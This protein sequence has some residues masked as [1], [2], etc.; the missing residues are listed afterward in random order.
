MASFRSGP[1][2]PR[3]HSDAIPAAI[4]NLL[5]E[6]AEAGAHGL[7]HAVKQ[8][9]RRHV[10]A[11]L[12]PGPH[13]PLWNTLVEATLPLLQ[14]HGSKAQLARILG[15]PRQRLQDCLKARTACLDAERT[16]LLL[17]WVSARHQRR[18]ILQ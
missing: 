1:W 3:F 13:T 8:R 11:T 2:R 12:R 6:A 18:T 10:G 5:Y 16:L 15:V 14:Q 4:F 7:V 9:R 17:C